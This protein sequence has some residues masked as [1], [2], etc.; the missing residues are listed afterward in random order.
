M[1]STVVPVLS[2]VVPVPST[3]V[4][5]PSTVVLVLS[6]IIIIPV[7]STRVTGMGTCAECSSS[8]CAEYSNYAAYSITCAEYSS[9]RTAVPV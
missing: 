4:P 7:L 6:R 3:V 1:W 8:T 9:T 5:V 2:T